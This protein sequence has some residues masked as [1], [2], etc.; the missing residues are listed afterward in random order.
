MASI[1]LIGR[2]FLQVSPGLGA[3]KVYAGEPGE[4]LTVPEDVA[5]LAIARGAATRTPAPKPEPEP[6]PTRALKKGVRTDG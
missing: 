1:T 5:L 4:T 2:L 3:M 6:E